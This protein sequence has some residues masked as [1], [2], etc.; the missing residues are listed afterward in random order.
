M[1]VYCRLHSYWDITGTG[2]RCVIDT[3]SNRVTIHVATRCKSHFL[4]EKKGKNLVQTAQMLMNVV[5]ITAVW[6]DSAIASTETTS[7][8]GEKA[9]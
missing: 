8:R 1:H 2:A 9:G 6:D 3:R 5:D 4:L 7:I